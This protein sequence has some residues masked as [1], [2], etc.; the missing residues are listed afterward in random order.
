M[1]GT[2]GGARHPSLSLPRFFVILDAMPFKNFM[3]TTMMTTTHSV[4]DVVSGMRF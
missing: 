2:A 1:E 3:M 4:R